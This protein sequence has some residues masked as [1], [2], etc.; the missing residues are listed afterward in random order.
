MRFIQICPPKNFKTNTNRAELVYSFPTLLR[1]QGYQSGSLPNH[2]CFVLSRQL[3]YESGRSGD[4]DGGSGKL[5]VLKHHSLNNFSSRCMNHCRSL[6]YLSS[7]V[8]TSRLYLDVPLSEPGS[9]TSDVTRGMTGPTLLI[10]TKGGIRVD[11]FYRVL[12]MSVLVFS[13]NYEIT[14][15][16]IGGGPSPVW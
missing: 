12:S 10:D 5:L 15:D 8:T 11:N 13:I 9:L 1:P 4:G 3:V 2:Q 16:G 14:E 7:S 6:A